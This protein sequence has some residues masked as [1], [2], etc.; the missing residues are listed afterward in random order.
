[1]SRNNKYDRDKYPFPSTA[2]RYGTHE[3]LY[4]YLGDGKEVGPY[5]TKLEAYLN[6]L[7]HLVRKELDELGIKYLVSG[8]P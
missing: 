3:W 6:Y 5:A 7:M 1:M 8:G 2:Y 4:F